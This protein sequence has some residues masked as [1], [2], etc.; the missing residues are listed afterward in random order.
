MR[1]TALVLTLLFTRAAVAADVAVFQ[2]T[3]VNLAPGQ[4][5]AV[6]TLVAQAYARA[7]G[8]EVLP[9]RL[10]PVGAGA[11]L[12]TAAAALGVREYLELSIIGLM[13]DGGGRGDGR[14]IIQGTRRLASG[15]PVHEVE[16]TAA[17]LADVQ[18]V[19][20]RLARALWQKTSTDAT[21]TLRTVTGRE[22]QPENR[23]FSQ[24][25]MGVK[26]QVAV[27]VASDITLQPLVALGFDGRLE[28]R[29]YFLEFGAG[30]E[31]P[32][33]ARQQAHS[34]GG[35]YGELGGS[36]YLSEG[37]TSPYIGAGVVPRLFFGESDGGAWLG[38][39]GQLGVMFAREAKTRLYVDLRVTQNLVPYHRSTD[40]WLPGGCGGY[41][42]SVTT[43]QSYYPTEIGLQLGI[44]W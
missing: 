44:G 31:V 14:I 13:P 40:Q 2:P 4:A 41:G 25:V 33:Q 1:S 6:A 27:P 42:C 24:K 20:D 19:A 39:Y 12:I 26:T 16:M 21:R 15:Q 34:Y 29:N 7:S 11:D 5:E 8:E 22:A 17:S 9:P 23:T 37:S 3:V 43:T 32:T 30:L 36:L 38:V 10:A 28:G 18:P 35:L